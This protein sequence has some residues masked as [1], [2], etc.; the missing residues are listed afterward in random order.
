MTTTDVIQIVFFIA[1][2]IGLTPIL[3]NYMNKVFSGSKHFMLPVLGG[4]EKLCYIFI[5]VNPTEE[6]N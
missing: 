1:L 5:K 4:L 3:G 2:I 6:T